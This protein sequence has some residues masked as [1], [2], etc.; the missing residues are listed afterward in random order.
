MNSCN[1]TGLDIG[2]KALSERR[3]QAS[4]PVLVN[5][6][7]GRATHRRRQ[8]LAIRRAQRFARALSVVIP[9]FTYICRYSFEISTKATRARGVGVHRERAQ[10]L[11]RL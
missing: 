10:I 4:A 11:R 1:I 3:R 5:A 6:G 2:D 9:M 8:G 7:R